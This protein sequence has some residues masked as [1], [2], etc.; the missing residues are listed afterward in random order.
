MNKIEEDFLGKNPERNERKKR[1]DNP[2]FAGKK[3]KRNDGGD[4]L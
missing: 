3:P 1:P 2:L 4:L